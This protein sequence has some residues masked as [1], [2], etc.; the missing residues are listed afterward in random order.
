MK[1]VKFLIPV[2]VM[3]TLIL[4]AMAQKASNKIMS[5]VAEGKYSEKDSI[6]ATKLAYLPIPSTKEDYAFLQS[7]GK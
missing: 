1:C 4:P 2:F 5:S 6:T 3:F 7:E